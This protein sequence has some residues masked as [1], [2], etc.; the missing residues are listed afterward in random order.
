MTLEVVV[1]ACR[2]LKS[3]PGYSL[4]ER[5][6]YY[7]GAEFAILLGKERRVPSIEW[8]PNPEILIE[9]SRPSKPVDMAISLGIY[10]DKKRAHWLQSWWDGVEIQFRLNS[11][12]VQVPGETNPSH[13]RKE[14]RVLYQRSLN[15]VDFAVLSYILWKD[16]NFCCLGGPMYYNLTDWAI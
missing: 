14:E 8:V 1:V 6:K 13:K 12:N 16:I 15:N 11:N 7:I 9:C 2:S 5:P 4:N 3:P 10:V